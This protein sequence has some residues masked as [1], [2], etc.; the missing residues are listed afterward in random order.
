[1]KHG[2]RIGR[3][4]DCMRGTACNTFFLR[5]YWTVLGPLCLELNV[6]H[7]VRPGFK[8]N[9]HFVTCQHWWNSL[10]ESFVLKRLD[11]VIWL[12]GFILFNKNVN[13]FQLLSF[14]L[15]INVCSIHLTFIEIIRHG[16]GFLIC[17]MTTIYIMNS[18]ILLYTN[19]TYVSYMVTDCLNDRVLPEA[20]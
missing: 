1:M 18:I 19:T 14:F 8:I 2:P 9:F 12:D 16:I 20:S 15:L 13:E 7:F 10:H 3:L 5:C 17:I 4:C 11:L 6:K